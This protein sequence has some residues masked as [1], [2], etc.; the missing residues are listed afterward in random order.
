MEP[1]LPDLGRFRPYLR[2]L[3]GLHVD[4]RL[5]GKFDAS[6]I[7]QQTLL[8]A[9]AQLGQFQGKTEAELAAWLRQILAHNLTDAMKAFGRAKRD[10]WRE[11]P[12][13][14]A[15][16]ASSARLEQ[17]LATEQSSPSTDAHRAEQALQLAAALEHLPEAQRTALVLQY[18]HGWT[19]AQI[20]THLNRTPAAVAGLLKRGLHKLREVLPGEA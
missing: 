3:A 6:D 2:L 8:E 9:Q 1:T 7:V 4:A 15:L 10:V 5:Q 12:L 17:W 14:A 13:H 20:G 18:W 11:Q 19:L 16:D